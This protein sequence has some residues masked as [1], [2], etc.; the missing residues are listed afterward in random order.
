MVEFVFIAPMLTGIIAFFM[1]PTAGRLLLVL[2][3]ADARQWP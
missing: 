2:T 3:G 1:P